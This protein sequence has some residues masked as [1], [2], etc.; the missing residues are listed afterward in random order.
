MGEGVFKG[1]HPQ[2]KGVWRV[3]LENAE[4]TNEKSQVGTKNHK[5]RLPASQDCFQDFHLA[6]VVSQVLEHGH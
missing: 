1:K 2:L 3:L 4:N 5:W 6:F